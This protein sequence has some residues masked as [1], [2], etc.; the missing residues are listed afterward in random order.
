VTRRRALGV[1]ITVACLA[2]AVWLAWRAAVGDLGAN[3]IETVEHT[4]GAWALR[5]LLA[6]LAVTPLRRLTGWQAIATQRRTLGLFAFAYASAH[7]L[8]WSVLDNGLDLAAIAEDIAKRPFVTVGFAAFLLLIPL[9]A[10][11]TRASIRRLGKRWISLH[12]AVYLAAA[13]GVLHFFW[14]VKKDLRS[15]LIHAAVLAALLGARVWLHYS[16]SRSS[17]VRRP[18]ARAFSMA[19]SQ[20]PRTASDSGVTTRSDVLNPERPRT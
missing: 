7:F 16:K 4:T 13:L 18:S 10:T 17:T 19:R 9:A 8:T 12:R 14:L 15:P 5:L 1:A 20:S 2:P 3:P 6:T 11:S